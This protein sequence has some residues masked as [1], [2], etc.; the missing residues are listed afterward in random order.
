MPIKI[1][2]VQTGL[3]K[4]IADSAK[5]AGRNLK[6]NLG[7]NAKDIKSLEQPLGRITGQADEF[8]KSMEAANARVLAFGASVGIINSVVQSFKILI[9][10]TIEVEK[11]LAKINSILKTNASGLS[12]LKDQIFSIAKGTEQTFDT[13]AEAALELSR[14][15]L[16]ATEVTKRLNDSLILARLSGLS[17]SEAVAGLT[18]AVNSFTKAGLTTSEVLNKISNAANQFAV[19]ERDLIEG[20]K[21]SAS[22]A[23]LAG[24]SID[25]LG[26]IITAVQ[27][28]TAR[29]GAVIGN[30]FKTIFTRIGRKD[31]LNLLKSLGV[32]ITD[33]QGKI[34]PA[35]KLIENLAGKLDSLNEIQVRSITQKIGGGFQIAPLLAALSDYSSES[36][37]AIKATEAFRNATD[38]AYQKNIVL[39]KTLAASINS[40]VL[41]VKEL[42]NALGEIGVTDTFKSIIGSVGAFVETIKKVLTGEGIGST[43]A[44]GVVSGISSVLIKGGLALFALLVGKLTLQLAKFGVESFKTFFGLNKAA[45]Q[46]ENTQ[47]QIAATLLKDS[48]IRKQ[49]LNIENSTATVAVKRAQQAAVFTTA[50]NEQ[51]RIVTQINRISGSISGPVVRGTQK[52]RSQGL[53]DS[54]RT[55]SVRGAGGF[56][57]IGAEQK[58]INRGVGGAPKGSKPVVIP[59]F[60]FGM[61]KR[62]TMVANDS[63]YIVPNFAGG[64]SAIF[65]QDMVNNIG[66]PEGAKKI[67]SAGGFIPNFAYTLGTNKD[68]IAIRSVTSPLDKKTGG[69]KRGTGAVKQ[70]IQAAVT[71]ANE[72]GFAKITADIISDSSLGAFTKYFGRA[73]RGKNVWDK[74]EFRKNAAGGYVP[75]FA[76]EYIN[77]RGQDF[78]LLTGSYG[79]D[80]ADSSFYA[81]KDKK[82]QTRIYES[83]EKAGQKGFGEELLTKVDVPTYQARK[84]KG[85]AG[86]SSY[87]DKLEAEIRDLGADQAVK[88]AGG[89][90]SPIN[91]RSES[92]NELKGRFQKGAVN[93]LAGSVFEVALASLLDGDGFKDYASRTENSLIDLPKSKGIYEAFGVK[94]GQG[95]SGAEVKGS[96]SKTLQKSAAKKFFDVLVGSKPAFVRK[97]NEVDQADLVG[98]KLLNEDAKTLGFLKKGPNGRFPNGTYTIKQGDLS[99]LEGRSFT[100]DKRGILESSASGYIPNFANQETPLEN[101]IR[102]ERAAG[103]NA[104]QIRV[105]QSGKLRNSQNPQGLAVTNTRDE[106]TGRIPNFAITKDTLSDSGISSSSVKAFASSLDSLNKKIAELNQEVQKGTKSYEEASKEASEYAKTL[107]E[108][109][110]KISGVAK[111]GISNVASGSIEKKEEKVRGD[112]TAKLI[113][114]SAIAFT[115]QGAFSSIEG[116][117]TGFQKGL[118]GAAESAAGAVTTF[119]LFESFGQDLTDTNSG[120][121]GLINGKGEGKGGGPGTLGLLGGKGGKTGK[122]FATGLSKTLKFV[123]KNFTKLL[124]FVGQAVVAFQGLSAAFKFLKG[125]ELL[126]PLTDVIQKGIDGFK[127]FFTN[128]A[129]KLN[130]I[131][132]PAEKAAQALSKLGEAAIQSGLD[133]SKGPINLAEGRL[134]SRRA[135]LAGAKGEDGKLLTDPAEIVRELLNKRSERGG[136]VLGTISTGDKNDKTLGE[137]ISKQ[138]ERGILNTLG[139]EDR[140]VIIDNPEKIGEVLDKQF[141]KLSKD[142]QREA[143]AGVGKITGLQSKLERAKTEGDVEEQERL[144]KLLIKE[145][146]SQANIL[147][148]LIE[149]SKE[150]NK[151]EEFQKKIV[152]LDSE[153]FKIQLDSNLERAKTLA[154]I[155]TEA[156]FQLELEASSGRA[157]KLRKDQIAKEI[158]GLE[159]QKKL[160]QD[161]S[162]AFVKRI[163]GN[164]AIQNVLQPDATDK[165][166]QETANKIKDILVDTNIIL[167]SG[168]KIEGD[169]ANIVEDRLSKISGIEKLSGD[170]VSVIRTEITEITKKAQLEQAI[171]EQANARLRLLKLETEEVSEQRRQRDLQREAG[172]I[173]ARSSSN[174][175]IRALEID[176]LKEEANLVGVFGSRNQAGGKKRIANLDF[177]IGQEQIKE[178]KRQFLVGEQNQLRDRIRSSGFGIDKERSQEAIVDSAT[179]E[180]LPKIAGQIETAIVLQRRQQEEQAKKDLAAAEAIIQGQRQNVADFSTA[181]KTATTAMKTNVDLFGSWVSKLVNKE[182]IDVAFKNIKESESSL[183][184]KKDEVK[185]LDKSII[186][187]EFVIS[188]LS[189]QI[190][191]TNS[192]I[193]KAAEI[194][195]KLKPRFDRIL[196]AGGKNPNIANQSTP[197]QR[198]QRD[199]L[200][201]PWADIRT[202]YK[203][204][205][206]TF[207]KYT[208][209]LEKNEEKLRGLVEKRRKAQNESTRLE[210]KKSDTTVDII[211]LQK[212]I[213]KDKSTIKRLGGDAVKIEDKSGE[214]ASK[215][216]TTA[217]GKATEAIKLL[218]TQIADLLKGL[219][220]IGEAIALTQQKNK[221]DQ[222]FKREFEFNYLTGEKP[223]LKTLNEITKDFFTPAAP[224]DFTPAAPIDVSGTVAK[225]AASVKEVESKSNDSQT[226]LDLQRNKSLLDINASIQTANSLAAQAAAQQQDTLGQSLFKART[227]FATQD[228]KSSLVTGTA[229]KAGIEVGKKGGSNEERVLAENKILATLEL[230]AEIASEIDAAKKV[231]LEFQ[232]EKTIQIAEL[233]TK[234]A[235][236]L[237][238]GDLDGARV[239]LTN[240]KEIENRTLS[241]GKQLYA[242]LVVTPE[243]GKENFKTA[244]VNASVQFRDNVIEGMTEAI[245]QGGDLKDILLDAATSFLKELYKANLQSIAGDLSNAFSSVGKSISSALGYAAG[246]KVTGGSGARDDVPAMLMGGEYVVK[247]SSVSKFGEKF[248]DSINRGVVPGYNQGGLVKEDE[249]ELRNAPAQTGKGGFFTPGIE[250][251]GEISGRQNLL[252]FATQGSTAGLTDVISDLGGTGAYINLEPESGRLTNFGRNVGTPEQVRVQDAKR[253]ALG[254]VFEWQEVRDRQRFEYEQREKERKKALKR[255]LLSAA[256][257]AATG[258][259]T[260]KITGS[261]GSGG[262]PFGPD[263]SPPQTIDSPIRSASARPPNF[264]T[265][266]MIPPQPG[267]DTV[268]TMLNGGEFIMNSAAVSRVGESNLQG[269]NAGGQSIESDTGISKDVIDKLEDLIDVS[270]DKVGDI[271]ITINGVGGQTQGAGSQQEQ[272]QQAQTGAMGQG[273]NEDNKRMANLIKEQVLLVL[274]DE[275]RLGGQLRR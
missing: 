215:G 66:L 140:K 239:L 247:K 204:T 196:A 234:I 94:E 244:F 162:N 176:K 61:G 218:P 100:S 219:P 144:Q 258:F 145:E 254:L 96:S 8:T 268:P 34:L 76:K 265:G 146:E 216:T 75:N 181:S 46:L 121:L 11:S 98:K 14:Q 103:L 151:E 71:K 35:T 117:L 202:E 72:R 41:S 166:K 31:N 245:T 15:G 90:S 217:V 253:Q 224:I 55:G 74:S 45:K 106:P 50:L 73:K 164:Q 129:E 165:I 60:A 197:E 81:V 51:L 80:K 170:I 104:N 225:T 29:G 169:I 149:K 64:G 168:K 26:G 243:Q 163:Q 114:L 179:L 205:V 25:E 122:K 275:K 153:R 241:I 152:K 220:L 102:R 256:I 180:N 222:T 27:Q 228:L 270:K 4:S 248:M 132:T 138:F 182:A 257:S 185:T 260:D 227:S 267:V 262:E 199:E 36:S 189:N 252:D 19:S 52:V 54:S 20:F 84:P 184:T 38:E 272:G 21:R 43:F 195:S 194:L 193:S 6:I 30:S 123:T 240:I 154:S 255:A 24:V 105:N 137:E 69:R 212:N 33:V 214:N 232:L 115:L 116:E 221:Q 28:K 128:I 143:R 269:L 159:A 130:I 156:Q 109:K 266:G 208:K 206:E 188:N 78:V 39:N 157:G 198:L 223:T 125:I 233:N 136:G 161:I 70:A 1:P 231:A 57:P 56:L 85:D 5:K 89:I 261:F 93:S 37:V 263:G 120:L 49:I 101:A 210:E 44:R 271:N 209:K 67:N 192:D 134:S 62:G 250:G 213:D 107:A 63:E 22:V 211:N 65:N 47:R 203:N 147:K 273:T 82:N 42:A 86:G 183:S 23:E 111:E 200:G 18:A 141:N 112:T 201:L 95:K 92:A 16:S 113:G 174:K 187:E 88:T 87:I 226:K 249:N 142:Q 124:P 83:A 32:D 127:G 236:L 139:T 12:D 97:G 274:S 242:A 158:R 230:E 77:Q 235:D 126:K 135:A 191:K 264:A 91:V 167:L 251:Y 171:T 7:T 131:D 3:E 173:E 119:A 186:K 155:K 150:R 229:A 160:N 48:S 59:N 40:T 118:A 99:R 79:E 68:N 2:V 237:Q 190:S 246:G 10:T 259:V 53:V 178:E 238:A 108:G 175:N 177:E 13:V 110:K 172:E 133:L 58:D 207:E 148:I 9:S 17:A